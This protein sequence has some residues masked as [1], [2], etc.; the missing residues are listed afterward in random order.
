M[1]LHNID[2]LTELRS[3]PG[4]DPLCFE[5]FRHKLQSDEGGLSRINNEQNIVYVFLKYF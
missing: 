4:S 1:N 5:A 3:Q 2:L